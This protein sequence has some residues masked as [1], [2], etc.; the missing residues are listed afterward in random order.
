MHVPFLWMRPQVL[1]V[2][3]VGW[4]ELLLDLPLEEAH[5]RMHWGQSEGP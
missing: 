1:A 3:A 5:G 2:Q 4:Q